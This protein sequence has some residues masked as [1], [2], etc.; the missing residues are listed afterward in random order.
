M[1]YSPGGGGCGELWEPGLGASAWGLD[2]GNWGGTEMGLEWWPSLR[3]MRVWQEL[4]YGWGL[5]GVGRGM[6]RMA[7]IAGA[8]LEGWVWAGQG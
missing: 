7:G 5:A 8:W 2:V 6:A 4:G 1:T 3:H